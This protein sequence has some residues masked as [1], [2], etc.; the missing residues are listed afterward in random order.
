MFFVFVDE[1]VYWL[2]WKTYVELSGSKLKAIEK[3][4][5]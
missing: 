3:N 5:W 2:N 4:A 1:I